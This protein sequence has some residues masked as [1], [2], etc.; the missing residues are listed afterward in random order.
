LCPGGWGAGAFPAGRGLPT[1]PPSPCPAAPRG[2]MPG[3]SLDSLRSLGMTGMGERPGGAPPPVIP[4]GAVRR[5]T[6]PCRSGR[7]GPQGHPP[8]SFRPERPAGAPPLSFRPERPA[9]APSPVIPTGAARRGTPPVIPTGAA[10]RGAEWRNLPP[11]PPTLCPAARRGF[12]PGRSLDSLRSLGM[13]GIGGH[14][15]RSG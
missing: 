3:R 5:G 9:G 11:T 12:M 13:T 1:P 4:A 2:S 10:R 6:L 8:L 14:S 15:A 7:S